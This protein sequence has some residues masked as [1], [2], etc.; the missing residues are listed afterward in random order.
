MF[1]HYCSSCPWPLDGAVPELLL[2]VHLCRLAA[3]VK[4]DNYL[5]LSVRNSRQKMHFTSNRTWRDLNWNHKKTIML[6][7][8]QSSCCHLKHNSQKCCW[9]KF[10]SKKDCLF[11]IQDIVV[12]LQ[13]AVIWDTTHWLNTML[14]CAIIALLA[15]TLKVNIFNDIIQTCLPWS[16]KIVDSRYI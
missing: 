15:K 9:D 10:L 7:S 8:Y 1:A 11:V 16:A 12:L 4:R 5:T 2:W 13:N 3:E 14:V 6:S